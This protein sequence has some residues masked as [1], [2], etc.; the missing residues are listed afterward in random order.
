MIHSVDGICQ[1]K[2]YKFYNG[3]GDEISRKHF[4]EEKLN[5]KNFPLYFES[6]TVRFAVL[7]RREKE[8]ILNDST[9]QSLKN[10]LNT[11]KNE[12]IDSKDVIVINYLTGVPKDEQ[13]RNYNTTWNIFDR[14]Y[15]RKLNRIGDISHF[16]ISS[17]D[18]K[19]LKHFYSNRIDWKKDS[20]DVI[21]KLFFPYETTY[22]YYIII[23]SEGKYYYALGEYGKYNVW[24]KAE[25]MWH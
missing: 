21:P 19:N 12:Q 15:I 20:E 8:G 16:W 14:D 3:E 23:N 1:N 4:Y 22:G 13:N 2:A 17:L 9:F 24:E 10:Y 6:D 11:F 18:K 5:Y 7:F 25:E